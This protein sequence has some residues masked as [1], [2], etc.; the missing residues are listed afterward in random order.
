MRANLQTAF[1]AFLCSL[2]VVFSPLNTV[3]PALAE[4]TDDPGVVRAA[5]VD[6]ATVEVIAAVVSIASGLKDIFSKD[7]DR[8]G[9]I[10]AQLD[11][12]QA[13][14]GEF[15]TLMKRAVEIL[16]SINVI[17]ARE[18]QEQFLADLKREIASGM[19]IWAEVTAALTS[20]RSYAEIAM[21]RYEGL[22]LNQFTLQSRKI[23]TYGPGVFPVLGQL[24]GYEYKT[25]RSIK[26]PKSERLAALNWYVVTFKTIVDPNV[27]GSVAHVRDAA[28]AQLAQIDAALLA[29]DNQL[30]SNRQFIRR[31]GVVVRTHCGDPELTGH[32]TYKQDLIGRVDGDRNSRYAYSEYWGPSYDVNHSCRIRRDPCPRF[33]IIATTLAGNPSSG[34]GA[35]AALPNA[36]GWGDP[37]AQVGFLNQL[38]D[39][40]PGAIADVDATE[41]ALQAATAYFTTAVEWRD[42]TQK[43]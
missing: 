16:E 21:K 42:R 39:L 9:E 11:S 18:V 17:I 19:Q 23:A 10:L 26:R 36:P 22:Y 7:D 1:T 13:Q 41:A 28:R 6:P 40:R 20:D 8:S 37:A 27:S 24:M 15:A 35:L 31:Q 38:L 5:F 2:F 29:A 25:A 4:T 12:L 30:A 43:E 14:F 3:R 34:L 33:C 32:I